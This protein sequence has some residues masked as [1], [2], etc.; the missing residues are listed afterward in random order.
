MSNQ[1]KQKIIISVDVEATG[2]SPATSSCVM[3]GAVAVLDDIVPDPTKKG[4]WVISQKAWCIS[5]IENKPPSKDCWNGFWLK[6]QELWNH[7]KA[8]QLS[9]FQA[10]AEFAA[11]YRELNKKYVVRFL[12]KPAS[13]DWQWINALYD[14]YG[15]ENKLKLPFSI[16]CLSSLLKVVD[17]VGADWKDIDLRDPTMPHTHYADEDALGQA[18]AYLKLV[19]WMKKNLIVKNTKN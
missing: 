19:D 11:W 13:Y 7:I 8:Q 9:P 17:I 3:I 1:Q 16:I 12:A 15:P 4:D 10:M 14:E 6:N 5:E 2:D 18:Y